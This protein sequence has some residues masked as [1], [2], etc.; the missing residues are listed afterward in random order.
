MEQQ[1]LPNGVLAIILSIVSLLC[2]C[3][4]G[5]GFIPAGIAYFLANKSEKMGLE[6]PDQYDNHSQI[7]T[8]KILALVALIINI[9]YLIWTVYRIATVGWDEIMEQ[10]RQMQEQLGM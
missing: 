7:K 1:K 10:S 9:L 8:A 4:G 2:C 6:N 3:I 5:I